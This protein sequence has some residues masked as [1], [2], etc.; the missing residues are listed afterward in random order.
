M[1]KDLPFERRRR[2]EMSGKSGCTEAVAVEEE[3]SSV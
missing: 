1:G 3:R 2:R